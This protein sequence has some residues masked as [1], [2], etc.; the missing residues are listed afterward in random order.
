MSKPYL[1]ALC[2]LQGSWVVV[3]LWWPFKR[4]QAA[5]KRPSGLW[6]CPQVA[7]HPGCYRPEP[8]LQMRVSGDN[9]WH[10]EQMAPNMLG[11]ISQIRPCLLPHWDAWRLSL[12]PGLW[13]CFYDSRSY[14]WPQVGA[15]LPSAY[16]WRTQVEC[17]RRDGF[18][19]VMPPATVSS[20]TIFLTT[21]TA[22][23]DRLPTAELQQNMAVR[24]WSCERALNTIGAPTQKTAR[25]HT[26]QAFEKNPSATTCRGELNHPLDVS[27]VTENG[28]PRKLEAPRISGC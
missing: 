20:A 2:A 7:Q 9:L 12:M 5:M 16:W 8:L 27:F 26:L 23:I 19:S 1:V 17:S 28:S 25:W 3:D 22:C 11:S 13:P 4:R 10:A 6:P 24:E 15:A 14:L 18:F 21:W